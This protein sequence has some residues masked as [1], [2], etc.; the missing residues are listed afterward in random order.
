MVPIY[1][2]TTFPI[3][4]GKEYNRATLHPE[5]KKFVNIENKNAFHIKR[6]AI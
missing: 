4:I 1:I 2:W 6:K 3:A 5:H